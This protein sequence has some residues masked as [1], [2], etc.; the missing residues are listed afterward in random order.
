MGFQHI[1][2]IINRVRMVHES[3]NPIVSSYITNL[4][5][6]GLK[7][8]PSLFMEISSCDNN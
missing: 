3:R 5:V 1:Y 4:Q 7:F 2:L 6:H 8:R